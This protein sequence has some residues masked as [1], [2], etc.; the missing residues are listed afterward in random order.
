MSSI[1]ITPGGLGQAMM[2]L[3]AL[4]GVLLFADAVLFMFEIAEVSSRLNIEVLVS[5]KVRAVVEGGIGIMLFMFGL[6]IWTVF[7]GGAAI[8][9]LIITSAGFLW[10]YNGT[11]IG[12]PSQQTTTTSTAQARAAT[13]NSNGSA[14]YICPLDKEKEQWCD[15][16]H[17]NDG[18]I[19]RFDSDFN[20][21]G[22]GQRN[23]RFKNYVTSKNGAG[24]KPVQK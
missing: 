14:R 20:K 22:Q 5:D 19:N 21:R 23:C 6:G 11:G 4:L 9:G 16:D 24:C 10:A 12:T 1:Q 13:P 18:T 15:E 3:L 17:D 7:V 8:V 2:I